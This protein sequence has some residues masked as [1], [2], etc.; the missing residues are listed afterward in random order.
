MLDDPRREARI[1][2]EEAAEQA[3]EHSKEI[4]I[5]LPLTIEER[6]LLTKTRE[7]RS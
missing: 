2:I 1:A 7:R 5:R 4:R 3:R 6:I